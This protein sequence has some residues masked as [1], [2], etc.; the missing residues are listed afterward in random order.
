MSQS[1]ERS[2]MRVGAVLVRFLK[3]DGSYSLKTITVM[4]FHTDLGVVRLIPKGYTPMENGVYD[5]RL[6][7]HVE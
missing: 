2:Q 1:Q 5:P 6:G 7:Y 3:E 4:Y